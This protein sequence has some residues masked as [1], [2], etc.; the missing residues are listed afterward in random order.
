MF[1]VKTNFFDSRSFQYIVQ[2]ARAAKYQDVIYDGCHAFQ[3]FEHFIYGLLEQV[4]RNRNS[5]MLS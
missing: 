1:R 2:I 5:K 3:D 4:S